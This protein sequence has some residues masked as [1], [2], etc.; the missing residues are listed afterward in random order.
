MPAGF[1]YPRGRDGGV[2]GAA[3][4]AAR[5]SDRSNRYLGTV[6]AARPRRRPATRRSTIWPASPRAAAGA[7]RPTIRSEM[8]PRRESLRARHF[9]DLQLRLTACCSPPGPCCSS[10]ASTSRSWRCCGRWRAGA[11]WRSAS[12][13]GAGRAAIVRQLLVEAA[14]MATLG[15]VG[16]SALAQ[17]AISAL[18]AFAPAGVPRLDEIA[19]QSAGRALHRRDPRRRHAD[20]RA[21]RQRWSP[22]TLRGV[23]DV[24]PAPAVPRTARTAAG[25]ATR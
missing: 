8:D 12:A 15:A 9:G 17:P 16:G 1:A 18:V 6:G 23:E 25:C 4:A 2:A 24:I 21:R 11:S 20:G 10:R 13:I 14:V 7:A 5:R 3:I 19:L 22:R